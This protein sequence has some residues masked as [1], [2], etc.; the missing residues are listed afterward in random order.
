MITDSVVVFPEEK[1]YHKNYY[2]KNKENI[3]VNISLKYYYDNIDKM[4]EYYKEF[5]P[6][7]FAPKR[8]KI[9]LCST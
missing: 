7:P 8:P 3:I 6:A 2:Q 4:K 5:L 1:I 9:S